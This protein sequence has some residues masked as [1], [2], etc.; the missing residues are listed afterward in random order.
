MFKYLIRRGRGRNEAGEGNG[1]RAYTAAREGGGRGTKKL[2]LD[3]Y[4]SLWIYT[5]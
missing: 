4:H 2:E 5:V 3:Q 1:R